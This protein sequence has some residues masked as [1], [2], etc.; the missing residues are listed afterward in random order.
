MLKMYSLNYQHMNMLCIFAVIGTLCSCH[1]VI[2]TVESPDTDVEAVRFE[3]FCL[4]ISDDWQ[5]TTAEPEPR[6]T[7]TNKS[8]QLAMS[9]PSDDKEGGSL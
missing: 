7:V 6:Q 1:T 9:S 4:K 3:E 2:T 5:C 8:T